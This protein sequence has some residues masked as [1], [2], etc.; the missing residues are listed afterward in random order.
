[1]LLL[2][3]DNINRNPKKA[4]SQFLYSCGRNHVASCKN[5]AVMYNNGDTGIEKD[6]EK[7]EKYKAITLNLV[8]Q[9]GSLGGKKVA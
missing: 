2:S 3:S 8:D 4:E 7:F 1:M 6:N 9:Y 5:L